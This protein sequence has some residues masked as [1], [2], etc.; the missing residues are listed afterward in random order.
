MYTKR[1]NKNCLE[2]YIIEKSLQRGVAFRYPLPLV[3]TSFY[4][5][6][7]GERNAHPL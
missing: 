3:K 1:K 6:G 5:E 2:M 7:G 4:K